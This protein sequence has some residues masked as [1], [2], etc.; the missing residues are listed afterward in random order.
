LK[1]YTK[2]SGYTVANPTWNFGASDFLPP[3]LAGSGTQNDF[4]WFQSLTQNSLIN[5]QSVS[6]SGGSDKTNYFF[7]GGYTDEKGF[8]KND[9][10]KRYS[11]RLNLD[12]QVT[13]WLTIGANTAGTFTDFSGNS[14]NMN[15]LATTSPLILPTDANGNYV[16]N[17]LGDVNTNPFLASSTDNKEVQSRLIGNFYGIITIPSL[18][19]FSYRLNF[20]N[21]LKYFKNY[22]SNIYGAGITG[23]ASKSDATQY[24]QTLDN[25][26]NYTKSFGKHNINATA[27]YGYNKGYY[28]AGVSPLSM[29]LKKVTE[30]LPNISALFFQSRN[31]RGDS[32]KILSTFYCPESA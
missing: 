19:G 22:T 2:E 20:G 30:V 12:T 6:L 25:I 10:Y 13:N 14:P 27:V 5:N 31:E 15:T 28:S 16:I 11:V 32:T 7:S 4:D 26:L 29:I 3:N 1:S 8:I 24:E 9:D 17:P 23:E 18:P 21:N